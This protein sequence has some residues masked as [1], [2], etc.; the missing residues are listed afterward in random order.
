[1][2]VA[3]AALLVSA[4]AFA[5][6]L[7]GG[8]LAMR[9]ISHV[10]LI[11]AFGAGIRIGAAYFD[12]I[13]ESVEHLGSLDAAM[14]FTAF[15]FLAFY[16]VEKV[17]TLH[18]GHETASELDHG[19]AEH[20]HIG[21][22][23]AAGMSLHSFLDGV[24]LAAGLIVGGGLGLVIG[25]VVVVHRFRDGIGIVSLLLASR[26]PRDEMIRWV[27]LVAVAPVIGVIVGLIVPVPDQVLG[28]MLAIFAGFFLYIGAA[29]LLPEA[30]R[31]D[32]SRWVVVA[33]LLGV[34]VIYGFSMFAGAVGA[35]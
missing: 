11:I 28:A 29:E 16:T 8:V 21:F 19:E 4:S 32:R 3:V 5:S 13:P 20:H 15:G 34:A 18:V 31:S 33:T 2:P 24:A 7:A 30:H 17:T 12:L 27:G 10:G 22:I 9:A 6:A 14:I 25:F 1:M 35:H 23:G 26:T